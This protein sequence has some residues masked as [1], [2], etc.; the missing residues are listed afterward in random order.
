MEKCI[1]KLIEYLAEELEMKRI[2]ADIC[3]NNRQAVKLAVRIGF[4]RDRGSIYIYE[5][6][7]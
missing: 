6:D 5:I 3:E 1:S 2:I 7:D 4:V